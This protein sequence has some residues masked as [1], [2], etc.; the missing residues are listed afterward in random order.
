MEAGAICFFWGGRLF[1]SLDLV[2]DVFSPRGQRP[3]A[4]CSRE[5]IR[6][7]RDNTLS[8]LELK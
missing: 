1:R 5:K 3:A 7:N 6:A 8:G 4:F 2:A